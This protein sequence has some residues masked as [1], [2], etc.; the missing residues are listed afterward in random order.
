[1]GL[2]VAG[3]DVMAQDIGRP[4]AEQGGGIL[5]V[6]AG[7]AIYLH[8]SP[9]CQPDRPVAEAIV[10]SLFGAGD[11]GRIPS[12]AVVENDQA[13]SVCRTIA[14]L[15]DGGSRVV[16]LSCRDGIT[17]GRRRLTSVPAAN[18]NGCRTLLAHPRPEL[19][20]CELTLEAIR[21]EGLP[22][23]QCSVVVLAGGNGHRLCSGNCRDR[24]RSLECLADSLAPGGTVVANVEDPEV[25]ELGPP[26]RENL[27]AVA[28]AADQLY[29]VA[30]RRNGGRAVWLEGCH[31]VIAEGENEVARQD[32]ASCRP[33]E[34]STPGPEDMSA[35]LACAAVWAL[36][37][38]APRHGRFTDRPVVCR[39]A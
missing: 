20:I 17:I 13:C 4:L 25:A 27:V 22:F 8:R 19:V 32:L 34:A 15:A 37:A 28:L 38:G 1:V 11:D 31:A 33:G 30:H 21:S 29:L 5:E 10:G 2:D 24:S 7:P 18:A 23:D 9:Q 16:G 39:P 14:G 36:S 6:N 26:G 35:L 12:I 3:V